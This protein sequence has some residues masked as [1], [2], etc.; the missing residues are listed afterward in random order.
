LPAGEWVGESQFGNSD[1]WRKSLAICLFCGL[2]PLY[3]I[4]NDCVYF[5]TINLIKVCLFAGL[6]T[7]ICVM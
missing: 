5:R 4:V 7:E 1:D 3:Q 2:S 6:S